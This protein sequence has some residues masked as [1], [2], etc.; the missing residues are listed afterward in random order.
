M[1]MISTRKKPI[2]ISKRNA[3]VAYKWFDLK[4]SYLTH[5]SAYVRHRGKPYYD[6]MY[7]HHPKPNKDGTYTSKKGPG[8]MAFHSKYDAQRYCGWESARLFR[9]MLWGECRCI[10]RESD[11]SR[12]W[13]GEHMLILG[14]INRGKER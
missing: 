5:G 13:A 11:F 9:V 8:F 1:C 2:K 4:M 7:F 14:K 3:V 12:V 10:Q 6:G